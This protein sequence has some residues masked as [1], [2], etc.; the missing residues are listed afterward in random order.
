MDAQG[1]DG[2][3]VT[4]KPSGQPQATS[5]VVPAGG[6][7]TITVSAQPPDQVQ[8]GS[9]P[10]LVTVTGGDK[11]ATSQLTVTITGTYTLDVSTANQV[12][13]TTANAGS[14]SDL[15]LTLTNSGT[16]PLTGVTPS[17]K[18]PTGW[19]VAFEPATVA[20]IAPGDT[21]TVTAQITP[22]GDAIT[23]D[24]NVV[25]SAK[26]AEASGDVTIRVKVE[27]PAYWW[28]AGL[29]LIVVVFA[30]LYWVFR[31]YGRR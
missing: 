18:A 1:A 12:L 15:Q 30:G 5:T 24:Y 2:W 26:A 29:G 3:T 7:T 11:T 28:I 8:A 17:G 9:Y 25:V 10:V 13:S 4:A 19:T 6:T 20:T 27:T 31:T 21:A 16:A 14:R 23:G 22:T